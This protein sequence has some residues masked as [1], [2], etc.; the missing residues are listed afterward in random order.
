[1]IFLSFLVTK[2][3]ENKNES[4]RGGGGGGGGDG[5]EELLEEHNSRII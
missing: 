3:L 5:K 2:F 4:V 1:V